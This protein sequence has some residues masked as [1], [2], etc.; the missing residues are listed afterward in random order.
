LTA[1]T[2]DYLDTKI[3]ETLTVRDPGVA[4]LYLSVE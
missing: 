3:P 4:T 1:I 2:V